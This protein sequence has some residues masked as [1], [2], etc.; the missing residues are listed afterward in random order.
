MAGQDRRAA[1]MQARAGQRGALSL[2]VNGCHLVVVFGL[3]LERINGVVFKLCTQLLA[4]C[5][6]LTTGSGSY[7]RHMQGWLTASHST[8]CARTACALRDL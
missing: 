1:R 8:A 3:A 6:V 7:T 4:V 5:A 2:L